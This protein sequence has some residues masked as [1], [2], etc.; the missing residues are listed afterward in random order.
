MSVAP[1]L[2]GWHVAP[3]DQIRIGV[4]GLGRQSVGLTNGFHAHPAVKVV[5]GA[6]VFG[7]K[8]QRFEMQLRKHQEEI[9]QS[10][11]ISTTENYHDLL[12]REDIDIVII[13]SPDHWHAFQAI[14]ACKAGKDIYLEKPV[15]LTIPEGIEVTKAVRENNIVL[16]VGSQQRS[17]HNFQHAVQLIR[18]D[19]LGKLTKVN[20]WVGNPAVPYSLEEEPVPEDL[21]WEKWLGPNQFVHHNNELAP[22]ITLDP[23][24]NESFWAGWRWYRET[25]GGSLTDW[26]A[27]NFDIAQWA[28][29]KDDSG[30]V[31]IIPAGHNGSEYIHFVYDNGLVMANE[32]FTEDEQFGVR[33]E[34]SD[35]WIEVHRGQFRASDD[36]L[37]PGEP[38]YSEV[39]PEYENM[40]PHLADFLRSVR[41]RKDPIAPIEAGHRTGSVG[42]L[43]NIATQLN[44]PLQWDPVR[45]RFVN[46]S[47]ADKYLHREYRDG[48]RI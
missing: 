40:R 42:I 16:G 20:A 12:E 24:Q 38:Q 31:E 44:R 23:P 29:N 18:N 41:T 48:Y 5:A 28:L 27:H 25:G 3:S 8:R 17:D 14:D 35:A 45:E 13:S 4:I 10:I 43:G 39:E 22:A 47:E 1:M 33:F 26:G 19:R 6:D 36:E 30:P 21:N 11:E 37:L 32:P 34:S 46:D 2:K 7:R 9:G 15:T